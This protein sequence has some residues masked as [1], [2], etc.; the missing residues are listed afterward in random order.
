MAILRTR[1]LEHAAPQGCKPLHGIV[2]Y[3]PLKNGLETNPH[4]AP[5]RGPRLRGA[6][7]GRTRSCPV[8]QV[9]VGDTTDDA[10]TDSADPLQEAMDN[11]QASRR[12]SA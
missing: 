7:A 12:C 1:C 8:L 5:V 2:F 6:D 10:D 9:F 4:F 3:Y 11:Y